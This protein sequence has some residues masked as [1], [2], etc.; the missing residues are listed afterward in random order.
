MIKFLFT[1]KK[2]NEDLKLNKWSK[3]NKGVWNLEDEDWPC[4]LNAKFDDN[5]FQFLEM[6]RRDN[7]FYAIL[8]CSL[9]FGFTQAD[10]EI[11]TEFFQ[12]VSK[13]TQKPKFKAIKVPKQQSNECGPRTFNEIINL[14]CL[15]SNT[16]HWQE[17]KD[18]KSDRSNRHRSI[19]NA[20]SKITRTWMF[21]S[22]F[23]SLSC[24]DPACNQSPW[25]VDFLKRIAEAI[26]LVKSSGRSK[27]R[28]SS[29]VVVL[30]SPSPPQKRPRA[31]AVPV[32][33]NSASAS[34]QMSQRRITT[35]MSRCNPKDSV[36]KAPDDERGDGGSGPG[37]SGNGR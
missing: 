36:R 32:P 25:V 11:L 4:F 37:T 28:S 29:D 13:E 14:A 2:G 27:K 23:R 19:I 20:E 8:K 17:C 21:L 5:H 18:T 12:S 26:A 6:G 33:G 1:D 9:N 34:G 30:S 10:Q 31:S 22:I 35:F 24:P 15:K 3:E 7:E 16:G